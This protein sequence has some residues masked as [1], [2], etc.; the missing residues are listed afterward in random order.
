VSIRT[1]LSDKRYIDAQI[2]LKDEDDDEMR[3][4]LVRIDKQLLNEI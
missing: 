3:H 2:K 4:Y 1:N